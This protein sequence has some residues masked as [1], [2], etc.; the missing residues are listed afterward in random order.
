VHKDGTALLDHLDQ[1]DDREMKFETTPAFD[2]DYRR[3]K[4]EHRA[5]LSWGAQNKFIRHACL[6]DVGQL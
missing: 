2:A 6:P 4:P 1:L 3:L 5:V